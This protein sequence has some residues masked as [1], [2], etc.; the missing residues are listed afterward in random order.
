MSV[1]YL[2]DTNAARYA[3]NKRSA[4]MDR[5]LATTPMAKKKSRKEGNASAGASLCGKQPCYNWARSGTST[6]VRARK[7]FEP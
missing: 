3:I 5:H 2:L 1:R 4:A 6:Q 7:P